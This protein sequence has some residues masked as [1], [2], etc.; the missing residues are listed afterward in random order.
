LGAVDDVYEVLTESVLE[1]GFLVTEPDVTAKITNGMIY[2]T[3]Y[4]APEFD[5]DHVVSVED[6]EDG[7]WEVEDDEQDY[8]A[9]DLN[10]HGGITIGYDAE[11]FGVALYVA[12]GDG[13]NSDDAI[14]VEESNDQW[15]IGAMVS[16]SAAGAELSADVIKTMN[17]DQDSLL[18]G[19]DASYTLD[20][21]MVSL[22]PYVG[23]EYA[24]DDG[25]LPGSI[26]DPA[27]WEMAAG[28]DAT[29]T[30]DDVLGVAF[31]MN[32]VADSMDLE[33][34]FTEDTEGGFVPG[35]GAEVQFGAYE[36]FA[37]YRIAVDVSYMVGA[38]EPFAGFDYDSLGNI[39]ANA[40]VHWTGLPNTTITVE[41]DAPDLDKSDT[42]VFSPDTGFIEIT[43][44]VA[45]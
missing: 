10:Q 30:N 34:T 24:K 41:W 25:S 1:T 12:S 22:V 19:V 14:L 35:L 38:V 23:F 28:L 21:G 7:D 11:A 6:D 15:L 5:P 3:V 42:D 20:A 40:G 37:D 31:Y 9:P 36:S 33:A 27:I 26:W 2:V 44:E 43:A 16:V 29:F 8:L 45:M 39:M 32:D 4:A 18:F 13:Y 17:V